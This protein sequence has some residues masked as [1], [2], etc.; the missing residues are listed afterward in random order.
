MATGTRRRR[1]AI[2]AGLVFVIA[3]VTALVVT[4]AEEAVETVE[5][6]LGDVVVDEEGQLTAAVSLSNRDALRHEIEVWLTVGQFGEGDAWSRRVAELSAHSIDL[7]S[8][9]AEALS[10]HQPVAVPSGWYEVTA[11]AR[12][13][14]EDGRV[15]QIQ[16]AEAVEFLESAAVSR[17]INHGQHRIDVAT[18]DLDG[19]DFARI[20]GVVNGTASGPVLVKVDLLSDVTGQPWWSSAAAATFVEEAAPLEGSQISVGFDRMLPLHAGTYAVRVELWEGETLLDQ[21]L[22]GDRMT[23]SEPPESIRRDVLPS[24]ALAIVSIELDADDLANAVATVELQNL[25]DQPVEGL[26]WWLMAA[27]GDPAPWELPD[28]RSFEIGRRFEPFER[29]AVRLAIDGPPPT[30]HGFELSAWAHVLPPDS[31]GSVHSDGVRLRQLINAAEAS[32][33][34]A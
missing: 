29:R 28:A 33:E 31:D 23:I 24:G 25:S 19:G 4:G 13:D 30:G 7:R 20:A 15:I 14:G 10:W 18:L 9:E 26:M 3:S 8:G 21:I 27:P 16:A 34:G 22:L 17:V 1:V 2:V 5:M 11:W 6:A 12:V 32:D